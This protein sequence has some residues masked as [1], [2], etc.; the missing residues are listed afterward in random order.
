[1]K[2][3]IAMKWADALES[4]EYEQARRVLFGGN[5]YCCLGVLYRV[6]G[7]EFIKDEKGFSAATP[8]RVA[9]DGQRYTL[10]S[11]FADKCGMKQKSLDFTNGQFTINDRDIEMCPWL[12]D[13]RPA[14]NLTGL[15]D[16]GENFVTIADFIRRHWEE[17]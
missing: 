7:E 5:G 17:L 10:D 2:Q 9:S 13:H 15:N 11:R 6:M 12:Q 1:M 3:E 16:N 4:G 14:C 8:W